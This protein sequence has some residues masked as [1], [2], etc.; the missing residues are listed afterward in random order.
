MEWHFLNYWLWFCPWYFRNY[1][2]NNTLTMLPW[3]WFVSGLYS[4]IGY[5]ARAFLALQLAVL[6]LRG[7]VD[8]PIPIC[9][10]VL[11][12]GIGNLAF[13]CFQ[14]NVLVYVPFSDTTY[15]I[16]HEICTRLALSVFWCG[17][18][19][20]LFLYPPR[21]LHWC[22][23]HFMIGLILLKPRYRLWVRTS[24][25]SCQIWG[26]IQDNPTDYKAKQMMAVYKIDTVII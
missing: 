18:L 22:R 10:Y 15:N 8:Y 20:S 12:Y 17:L 6:V 23:C 26:H 24:H 1:C 13:S 14:G 21:K 4:Q 25:I 5:T 7:A 3:D 9:Y 11:L 16:F 19:R 2:V